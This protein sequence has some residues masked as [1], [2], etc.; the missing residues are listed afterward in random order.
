MDEVEK[1]E[2]ADEADRWDDVCW[3]RLAAATRG[4]GVVNLEAE[5]GEAAPLMLLV[6]AVVEKKAREARSTRSGLGLERTDILHD[7]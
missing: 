6:M 1:D 2:E 4:E 7:R 5:D 3:R